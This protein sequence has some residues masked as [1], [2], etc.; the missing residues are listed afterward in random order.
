MYVLSVKHDNKSVGLT[1][2]YVKTDIEPTISLV[3][4]AGEHIKS[5]AENM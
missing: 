3:F 4:P 1:R 2:S 5:V